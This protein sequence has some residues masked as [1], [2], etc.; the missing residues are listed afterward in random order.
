MWQ[1]LLEIV[2]PKNIRGLV[3]ILPLIIVVL[4]MAPCWFMWIFLPERRQKR[5]IDLIKQLIEWTRVT[6]E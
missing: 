2:N 4:L 5:V 3:S 1:V 6:R